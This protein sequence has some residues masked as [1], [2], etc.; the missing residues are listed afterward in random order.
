MHLA[1]EVCVC[2]SVSLAF[3]V[4]RC[5]AFIFVH[6]RFRAV[7]IRF[8]FCVP[9]LVLFDR[10]PHVHSVEPFP[11]V[12]FCCLVFIVLLLGTDLC[13]VVVEVSFVENEHKR[14]VVSCT[15]SKVGLCCV[16]L[17]AFHSGHSTYKENSYPDEL[18]WIRGEAKK[19]QEPIPCLWINTSGADSLVI[20]SHGKNSLNNSIRLTLFSHSLGNGCDIGSM[21]QLLRYYG[22]LWKSHV[23]CFEY[24]GLKS[25]RVC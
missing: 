15:E 7:P 13:L 20:F 1:A 4:V 14:A 23:L 19:K 5:C 22:K 3:A 25:S 21:H 9:L 11:L 24:P 18:F 12:V 2:E 8:A 6:L 16:A 17:T 10:D